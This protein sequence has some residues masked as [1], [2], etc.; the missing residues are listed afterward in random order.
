[1]KD[2]FRV[3][4]V[5]PARGGSKGI[6]G[7]NAKQLGGKPLIAHVIESALRAKKLSKVVLSTDSEELADIGRRFGAQVPFMRPKNIAGD[8]AS[9][10]DTVRHALQYHRE[11]GELFDAA[12]SLQPTCPFTKAST[13]DAAIDLLCQSGCETVTAVTEL[14]KG[15]PYITKRVGSESR[16]SNFVD[17]PAGLD[18]S[19]RQNR[20]T[21]YTMTGAMYLRRIDVVEDP[22]LKGHGLGSDSR[23]IIVSELE[24]LDINT[25]MDFHY[26]EFLF[27]HHEV[28]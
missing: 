26:A 22:N 23:G 9:L 13:I 18:I 24:A 19:T 2:Q 16:L 21:A 11:N 25:H 3:L 15:H 12:I 28:E 14:S 17:I 27:E 1:M 10:L 20:E 6:P 5:V 8:N 7:K 4:G